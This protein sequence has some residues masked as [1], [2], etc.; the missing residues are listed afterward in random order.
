MSVQELSSYTY[1]SKYARYNEKEKR[2]ETW[3]EACDR[4]LEMHLKR[5]PQIKEELIWAFDKVKEKKVLGSQ[6]VLQF[7]GKGVER[8]HSRAY[9]CCV[10]FCDRLRFFQEA[11]FLLLSGCGTGF[12]VQKHHIAK[13][14]RFSK[15]HADIPIKTFVV[16]DSIEGWSDALGVLLSSFFEDPVFPEYY[17]SI[18]IFDYSLIRPAGSKLSTSNGK[19]PGYKPLDRSLETIRNLL[20][21]RIDEGFTC[22]RPIDAY[23][24]AM[25]AS[26]AVLSGGVRRSATLCLFSPDDE[27][28]ANAKIGDWFQ[29]NPQ[30]ARSNN[31]ALLLRDKVTKQQFFDLLHK[32]RQWGEPGMVWSDSTEMVVNP[33]S[34]ISMYPV[35]IETGLSGWEY[36]NLTEI[37]GKLIKSKDD[38]TVAARAASIIGTA[39]AGYTDFQYL[40][41]TTEK[42]VRREAL[43]GVSIT[44]MMENPDIIFDSKTQKEMAELIK[45]VNS[46]VAIKIGINSAARCTCVKPSGT[47]SCLLET[48]SGIHPHH[49]RRYFRHVQ[50]NNLEEPFQFFK[51]INPQAIEHSTWSANK[52][53]SIISFCI[54]PEQ[55]AIVK[56]NLTAIQ[57][58]EKVKSTQQNWVIPGTRP[59][60]SVKPWLTH[61]VSNTITVNDYEWDNVGEFI[62]ENRSYF[63]GISLLP[64]CGDK[65][66]YQAPFCSVFS[67]E[68]IE[69][70]YGQGCYSLASDLVK[71]ALA[72]FPNLW[73]ACD[74]I[75]NRMEMESY[76]KTPMATFD[77][78]LWKEAV[79]E[80][81]ETYFDANVT[82]ATYCL[83]DVFNWQKWCKLKATY[84]NV[85]YSKMYE[86]EDNTKPMESIACA[87]GVC[88]ISF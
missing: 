21:G 1:I 37:N 56:E 34:E 87:G 64:S 68:E 25:H 81:A 74:V 59:E 71:E 70:T 75:L 3:E 55:Q 66:Y 23:D 39:Q 32:N 5:Y 27:E 41:E 20:I 63:V 62:Y 4:V 40:G 60:C 78:V 84:K 57:L 19:A 44:G 35:D 43:L 49:A 18:V 50:A 79:Q 24:I 38:F 11:F 77:F 76:I 6:R 36:C 85:D 47:A 17:N 72:L 7:G 48:S 45:K 16:P 12:S 22:L 33:C 51:K 10:S 52:T 88:E 8:N 53:D 14:P 28:M 30:R 80:F 26:D 42:I 83:K 2:R 13:L 29:N 58:L 86:E 69:K 9:N 67:R 54:E 65:D 46:E 15:R 73:S 31:S 82:K 61:N